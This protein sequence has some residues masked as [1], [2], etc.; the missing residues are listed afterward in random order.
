[1]GKNLTATICEI[2]ECEELCYYE[3]KKCNKCEDEGFDNLMS[4]IY[5]LKM[6]GWA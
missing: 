6:M 3:N 2:K 4:D 5:F 1:M